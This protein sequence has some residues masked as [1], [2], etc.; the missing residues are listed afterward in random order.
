MKDWHRTDVF[1]ALTER[2]WG[3]PSPLPILPE[4]AHYIGE[5]YSFTRNS[6]RVQVY[7]VADFGTGLNGPQ[8]I[9]AAIAMPCDEQLWLRRTRDT[10]WRRAV[11]FWAN[12]ISGMPKA[13]GREPNLPFR[14]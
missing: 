14:P 8:S 10:K 7:F 12:R 5:T 4:Q 13:G 2:G 3:A 1:A 11:A 9:E 6:E